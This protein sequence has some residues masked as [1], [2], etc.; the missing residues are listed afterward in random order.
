M[1]PQVFEGSVK[2]AVVN[3]PSFITT[4]QFA[5]VNSYIAK[6]RAIVDAFNVDKKRITG[7]FTQFNNT[8]ASEKEKAAFLKLTQTYQDEMLA[9]K[10]EIENKIKA[11][12]QRVKSTQYPLSG[13]DAVASQTA[14]ANAYALYKLACEDESI[15]ER[16]VYNPEKSY[17]YGDIDF[18]SALI[19]LERYRSN[20]DS[21]DSIKTQKSET[22]FRNL[23]GI[24]PLLKE[25]LELN[26]VSQ[27]VSHSAVIQSALNPAQK[28]KV[29]LEI[30]RLD[31]ALEAAL[32]DLS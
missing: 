10:T 15:R 21:D 22:T 13:K 32:Q 24:A 19:E 4:S 12:A 26:R 29:G 6:L 17:S 27:D 2:D 18:Y 31:S 1:I 20:K 7:M 5:S 9:L 14:I 16:I 8:L 23:L 3:N 30:K 11:L 28:L 25:M